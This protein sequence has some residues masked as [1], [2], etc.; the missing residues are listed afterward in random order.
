[1][2]FEK[3]TGVSGILIDGVRIFAHVLFFNMQKSNYNYFYGVT[4]KWRWQI[5]RITLENFEC[6][7]VWTMEGNYEVYL[8]GSVPI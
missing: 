6:L 5:L 7:L 3:C 4:L 8:Q 2:V 1:M